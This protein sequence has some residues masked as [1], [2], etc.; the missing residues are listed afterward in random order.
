MRKLTH[1]IELLV[2][3]DHLDFFTFVSGFHPRVFLVSPE[4]SHAAKNSQEK[5]QADVGY[6]QA[7]QGRT[8]LSFGGTKS[9]SVKAHWVGT[10]LNLSITDI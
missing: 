10:R 5:V 7:W 8:I 4:S 9:K 6:A 3:S 2:R 1:L